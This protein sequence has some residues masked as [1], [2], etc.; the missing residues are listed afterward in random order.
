MQNIN[1]GHNNFWVCYPYSKKTRTKK[2]SKAENS[3]YA[4][5]QKKKKKKRNMNDI[6][7]THFSLKLTYTHVVH[8]C[9]DN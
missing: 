2:K 8:V 5:R 4:F 7:F 3:L 9:A 6:P 1:C